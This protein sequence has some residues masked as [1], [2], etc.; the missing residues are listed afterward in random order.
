MEPKDYWSNTSGNEIV[1][2]FIEKVDKGLTKGEI[3]ALVAWETVTKEIHEELTYSNLYDSMDNIWSVL[4]MAEYLTMS[5]KPEGKR[6]RLAIP[7]MEIRNI[8]MGQIMAFY[9]AS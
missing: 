3:E 1:G 6:I 9:W 8:F 4:F 2:C 5:G 7:N